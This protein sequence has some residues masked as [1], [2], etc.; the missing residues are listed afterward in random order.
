[1]QFRL[2]HVH[3]RS[4]DAVAAASFYVETL[5]ARETGREGADAVTRMVLDLGGLT[6]FIEQAPELGPGAV[7]PHRGI[8]HIGLRVDDLD[9]AMAEMARR[10]VTV[11]AEIKE[12]RPGLRIA[13]IDGPDAVRI[14][15][16]QRAMP[17]DG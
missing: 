4:R 2:D 11:A 1:M 7:P 13:F 15:L 10:G 16:L 9:T 5:G 6:V 3:L 17:V 12:I 8:E 14:E